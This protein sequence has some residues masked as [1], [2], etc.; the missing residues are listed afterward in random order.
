MVKE[1]E[2]QIKSLQKELAEIKKNQASLRVQPCLGDSEMREKDEKLDELR[3][4][5]KELTDALRD[6][7]RRRQLILSQ[8]ATKGIYEPDRHK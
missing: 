8:N 7:T 6:A 2:N 3:Q 5:A 1:L 4:R